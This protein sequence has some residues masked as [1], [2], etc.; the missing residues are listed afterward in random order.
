MTKLHALLLWGGCATAAG[1]GPYIDEVVKERGP[2]VEQKLALVRAV[3]EEATK[4]PLIDKDEPADLQATITMKSGTPAAANAALI[5]VEDLRELDELGVVYARVGGSDIVNTC[6]SLVHT[7]RLP[8]DPRSPETP[9]GSGTGY[10]GTKYFDVCEKLD[11]VFVIRTRAFARPSVGRTGASRP[12]FD[13]GFIDAEVL[14]FDLANERRVGAFRVQAESDERLDGATAF[15]VEFDLQWNL[16]KAL[17]AGFKQN[18]PKV[19]VDG[20]PI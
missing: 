19:T 13:G 4:A 17:T 5:H 14:A 11:F 10:S 16:Q 18:M 8:W 15:E 6:S 7:E 9:P 3:A 12:E 1:C 2:R 20:G